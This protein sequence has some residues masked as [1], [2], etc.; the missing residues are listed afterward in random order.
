[1]RDI[2]RD[3]NDLG[4]DAGVTDYTRNIFIINFRFE[5]PRRWLFL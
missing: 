1:M 3:L 4:S 5:N 2:V